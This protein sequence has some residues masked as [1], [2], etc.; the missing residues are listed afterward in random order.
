MSQFPDLFTG[1]IP[2]DGPHMADLVEA[3]APDRIPPAPPEPP[4]V[5]LP[6]AGPRDDDY[7]PDDHD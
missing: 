7:D 4:V 6:D 5:L 1:G 3:I 2:A